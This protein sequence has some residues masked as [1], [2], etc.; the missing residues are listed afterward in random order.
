MTGDRPKRGRPGRI[1][2]FP[3]NIKARID[4]LLRSGV[5]QREILRCLEEPLREIGEP[6]LSRSGLNRYAMNMEAVGQDLRE[7]RAIADAWTAK[8]GEEPTGNVAALTIEVL[9]TLAF[10][11]TLRAKSDDDE[12]IDTALISELALA[13]QRL[14][15]AASLSHAREREIRKEVAEAAAERAAQSAKERA[16][17]S[18]NTL[19]EEVLQQ[20]RRDVYGIVDA[21]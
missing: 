12:T 14:E 6:P 16:S 1:E 5:T 17:A 4:E 11:A 8:L 10:K 3:R 7:A 19:P 18:G 13:L 9:R 21:A 2:Q 15:R 20:I